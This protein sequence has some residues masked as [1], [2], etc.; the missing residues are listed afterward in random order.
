M[1]IPVFIRVCFALHT[2][3]HTHTH[4]ERVQCVC[5]RVCGSFRFFIF[6]FIHIAVFIH[7]QLK[8]NLKLNWT[9]YLLLLC[10]WPASV[11]SPFP[12]RPYSGHALKLPLYAPKKGREGRGRE[13][14]EKRILLA[15]FFLSSLGF[16][17]IF[18][19]WRGLNALC[20]YLCLPT[21]WKGS[22]ICLFATHTTTRTHSRAH[23]HPH[24]HANF[25]LI[26]L[27]SSFSLFFV[28]FISYANQSLL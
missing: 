8:L 24:T 12:S 9:E 19:V 22:K 27:H 6:I 2:H 23:T 18:I 26:C 7:A 1:Q 28:Y 25:Q 16:L 14:K 10:L 20:R 17:F 11:R 15:Q 13:A 5:L 21:A 3:T 4:K